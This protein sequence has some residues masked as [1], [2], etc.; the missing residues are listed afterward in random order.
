MI[1][2]LICNFNSSYISFFLSLVLLFD[3]RICPL[4]F[5]CTFINQIVSPVNLTAYV[6]NVNEALTSHVNII[7]ICFLKTLGSMNVEP[8]QICASEIFCT[9]ITKVTFCFRVIYLLELDT[10]TASD[11]KGTSVLVQLGPEHK[12]QFAPI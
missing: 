3:Q 7:K 9:V 8:M 1:I 6:A 11:T 10:Q 5:A 4:T 2:F 12:N